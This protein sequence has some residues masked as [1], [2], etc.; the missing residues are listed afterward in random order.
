M[1]ILIYIAK[2]LVIVG[3]LNWGFVGIFD[4]DLIERLFGHM[5]TLSRIL[6]TL[7]GL[8]AVFLTALYFIQ[9]V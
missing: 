1:N 3:A 8:S 9:P 2:I 5:S 4:F 6:Y 7:V